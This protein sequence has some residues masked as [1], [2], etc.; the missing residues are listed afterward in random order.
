MDI[1]KKIGFDFL[2]L[3]QPKLRFFSIVLVIDLII[4]LFKPSYFFKENNKVNSNSLFPWWSPGVLIGGFI[5]L[6]L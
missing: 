6:F 1:F 2:G 5:E 3:N 4:W